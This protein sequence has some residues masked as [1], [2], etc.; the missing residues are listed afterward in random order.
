MT[1]IDPD[2]QAARERYRIE[3]DKRLRLDTL[4]QYQPATGDWKPYAE[5]PYAE[6]PER[7][8][9]TTEVDAVVLGAGLAG[10]MTGVR[11]RD[12]GLEKICV[13]DKA[14]DFGGVWYWNR[15]PGLQCD[16]ESYIYFPMLEETGYMPTE[17][18]AKGSEIRD[19]LQSLAKRHNLYEGALFGTE[20]TGMRWDEDRLRWI[21]STDRGDEIIAQYVAISNGLL[22][23][24]KFPRIPGIDT[25]RGHMFHTSRWDYDYTGGGPDGGL[26]GLA[27][28]EIGV[29]G[30]GATAMQVVPSTA[31]YAKHLFVFQRTPSTVSRRDNAPTDAEFVASLKPGWQRERMRNFSAF[32]TGVIPELNLVDDGW[33]DVLSGLTELELSSDNPT[34]EELAAALER[35][36]FNVMERI[37]ARVDEIVKDPAT[38][39]ALKPYYRALC[40]RP[41]FSDTY[42]Q[43]F[44]RPN[45]TLVD[46]EGK[47]IERFTEAGPVVGGKEYPLDCVLF[48]T[49]FDLGKPFVERI[50]FDIVGRDGLELS[51]KWAKGLRT[52]Y[53]LHSRGYPNMF[54]VGVTQGGLSFNYP[55]AVDEQTSHMRYVIE[56]ARER[57]L[58]WVEPTQ[59][60][61]DAW[62]AE[63][64][65]SVEGQTN[66]LEA[67]TPGYINSEGHID[68]ANGIMAG[69]YAAGSTAFFQLLSDWREEGTLAGL[70]IQR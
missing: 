16:V 8:P 65:S 14:G 35:A 32:G 17:K 51:D 68:N 46:T 60:A 48:A 9:V 47:G 24:P 21:V 66:F 23:T 28:K 34:P 53:G 5:D 40:K 43:A 63:I 6:A 33:T 41:G 64:H 49:G 44:N 29:V 26:S 20:I 42:L 2:I 56:Q 55:H 36:D 38:A 31:E 39:A 25:Y 12:A 54:F 13:I 4:D 70:E 52:L 18:Y 61:E 30:T 10:I 11:L 3:R 1:D 15:Y 7:D 37:R 27:D 45:V 22:H 62:V 59:E 57:G 19:Y 67:C 69:V 58:K 50:G